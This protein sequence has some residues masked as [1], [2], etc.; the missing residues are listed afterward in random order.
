MNNKSG[1]RNAGKIVIR[2]NGP[3]IIHG[4]I[5]LVRKIQI[6]SEYGEPLTW[7]KRETFETVETYTLCRCGNSRKKPFCD[8]SHT[9]IR[10]NGIETADTNLY[11]DRQVIYGGTNI[12]VKR[13]YSLCT[14]SGFCG[15]QVTN[16]K[17]MVSYTNDSRVRAQVIA[18]AER[19]PSGGFTFSIE[20]GG[21]DIEPDLPRQVAVTTEITSEGPIAG[22]LWITGSIPI[23]RSDRRPFET[24]NRVTVCRCG[25]SKNKPLCDGTHREMGI[26]ED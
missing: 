14:H 17:E 13:D 22:P 26:I 16:I 10:F 4:N 6:V 11:A 21:S 24:R 1:S 12:V 23:I 2:R 18:M 25:L 5:P 8:G 3:Y 15:N 20:E 7:E 19:C 9:K